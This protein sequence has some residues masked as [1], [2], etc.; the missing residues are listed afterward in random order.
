MKTETI[1]N[2]IKSKSKKR[3]GALSLALALA[4]NLALSASATVYTDFYCRSDGANIN[5]GSTTNA[6]A[7]YTSVSGNWDGAAIFIPTDGTTPASTVTNGAWAS[8][9]N[10]GATLAVYIGRVTNVVAGVNGAI[11]VS[12]SAKAGT[13]P[14][15]NATQRSIKIGG[16]WLGPN[17]ASGFPFSFV[18]LQMTNTTPD[19]PRINFL[20]TAEYNVSAAV[21]QANAGPLRFQGYASTPGDGGKFVLT[22]NGVGSAIALLTLSGAN[23][24]LLDFIIRSNGTSSTALGL[25]MASVNQ[26]VQRGVVNAIRGIGV[27]HA[28]SGTIAEVEVFDCGRANTAL[29]AGFRGNSSAQTTLINCISHDNTNANIAGFGG[30]AGAIHINCIADSNGTNGFQVTSGTGQWIM[31]N[32]ESYNNGGNGLELKGSTGDTGSVFVQNCNFIKNALYGISSQLQNSNKTGVVQFCGFGAGSQAN[33]SG[34]I[35]EA[36]NR[37]GGI[38]FR[39]STF[40][41]YAADVTPWVDPANGDF[42]VSLATAKNAGRGSFTQT[43]G[44]YTGTT[45]YPDIGAAQHLSSGSGGGSFTF[46]Q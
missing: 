20:N 29:D 8:V 3:T 25:A 21:S 27:Q 19:R 7:T 33:G 5:A 13:A 11:H 2:R 35:L 38:E 37:T 31:Q 43:S 24:D 34:T 1:K 16:A 10:D 45:G 26:T 17:A 44:S 12:G 32:C 15:S 42:R 18:T 6:A 28:S 30:N 14:T 36:G 40:V 22:G 9:Y 46:S 41:T 23:V 39:T 4:L